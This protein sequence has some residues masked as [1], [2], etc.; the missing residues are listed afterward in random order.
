[1]SVIPKHCVICKKDDDFL[2]IHITAQWD[3]NESRAAIYLCEDCK[4]RVN[5]GSNITGISI[6]DVI[7]DALVIGLKR[8]LAGLNPYSDLIGGGRKQASPRPARGD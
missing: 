1:M 5:P 6:Q 2:E 7:H 8:T 4:H 3:G